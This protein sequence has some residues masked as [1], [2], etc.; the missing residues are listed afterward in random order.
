M[1]Q[2]ALNFFGLLLLNLYAFATACSYVMHFT[3]EV[4][5]F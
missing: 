4:A 5:L 3:V 2:E 1:S